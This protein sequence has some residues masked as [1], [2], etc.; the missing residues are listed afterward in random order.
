MIEYP[1]IIFRIDDGASFIHIKDDE[2][3]LCHRTWTGTPLSGDESIM[4]YS[5][6]SLRDTRYF[7]HSVESL[8]KE[9]SK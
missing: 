5:Y 2:Y 9:H 6:K 4:R 8:L 7:A 1:L 3:K